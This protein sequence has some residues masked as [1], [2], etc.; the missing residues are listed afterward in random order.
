MPS[1][2]LRS[3]AI[4]LA[5]CLLAGGSASQEANPVAPPAL[6]G[7]GTTDY[8][9]LWTNPTTLGNSVL[10]QFGAG[11]TAKVGINTTTP[12]TTLDVKG[13]ATVRGTLTLPTTGTATAAKGFDSQSLKL[14][15]SSFSSTSSA[16]INYSFDWAAEPVRN[17]TSNPSA[18]LNLLFG[19]G[20]GAAAETG[21]RISNKGVIT[22]AQGQIFPG[23]GQGTVTSI[24]TGR[25]LT[26]G[27]I[28]ATG[29]LA[30]DPTVVPLLSASNSFTGDQTIN[31]NLFANMVFAGGLNLNSSYAQAVG[32]SANPL[33]GAVGQPL[34]L[35]AGS[36]NT[37]TSNAPGGD[38]YLSAGLGTGLGGG[39]NIHIQ[40]APSGP[41]EQISSIPWTANLSRRL[42]Y[43]WAGNSARA[44]PSGSSCRME[45]EAAW[46]SASLS[47]LRMRQEQPLPPQPAVAAWPSPN[48]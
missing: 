38:L 17:N 41:L 43:R 45:P 2:L 33:A 3:A 13:M 11:A 10:F 42:Q 5:I 47:M 29:T 14:T 44:L 35:A 26:G 39:G 9:P 16:P 40:A 32:M 24:A 21:L 36:A 8:F 34:M 23:T 22:F 19:S 6:S 27:P 7:T 48:C 18:T 30:V 1:I 31:G 12:A 37:G 15:A 28:T 20:S 46:S 4:F 25:G